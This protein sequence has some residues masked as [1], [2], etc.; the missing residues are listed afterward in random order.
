MKAGLKAVAIALL[1]L[2]AASLLSTLL[3]LLLA[4]VALKG[5]GTLRP[6]ELDLE[7]AR[8]YYAMLSAAIGSLVGAFGLLLG[9]IYYVHRLRVESQRAKRDRRRVRLEDIGRKIEEIDDDIST[10]LFLVPEA[11]VRKRHAL[12]VLRALTSVEL[13]L[14]YAGELAELTDEKLRP[15]VRFDSYLDSFCRSLVSVPASTSGE[16]QCANI[17]ADEYADLLQDARRALQECVEA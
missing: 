5:W 12:K 16:A 15:V 11:E 4:P 13:L 14:D 2:V 1:G 3:Y 7:G 9:A 6:R 10:L 17:D 8:N